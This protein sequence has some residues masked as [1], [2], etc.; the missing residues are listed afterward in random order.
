MSPKPWYV[1]NKNIIYA[2]S[3]LIDKCHEITP[4]YSSEHPHQNQFKKVHCLNCSYRESN[5]D[6]PQLAPTQILTAGPPR[7]SVLKYITVT[8]E[9]WSCGRILYI[10]G[11]IFIRKD[12]GHTFT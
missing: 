4:G 7:S 1:L 2:I 3:E 10:N 5:Q 6:L 11:K 9:D 12:N 8:F